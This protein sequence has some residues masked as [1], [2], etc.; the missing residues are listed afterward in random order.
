[1]DSIGKSHEGREIWCLTVTNA[2]TGL[3]SEKPA[4]WIDGNIHATEVSA[5]SACIYFLQKLITAYGSDSDITRCLDTRVYY[6]VPRVNPDGAELYF[7][8]KPRFLRSSTRPY[9]YDEEPLDGL[10]RQD[11]DGDGRLLQMRI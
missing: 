11:V 8:D 3:A 9:P 5:A 2:K 1:M 10:R 6:I 4:L 7:S